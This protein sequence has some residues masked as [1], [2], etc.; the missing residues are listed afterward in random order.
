MLSSYSV[1]VQ[2]VP[3]RSAING[4]FRPGRTITIQGTVHPNATRSDFMG[5]CWILLWHQH[6]VTLTIHIYCGRELVTSHHNHE[7][8]CWVWKLPDTGGSS[9]QLACFTH[10]QVRAVFSFTTAGD[11]IPWTAKPHN[12][13]GWYDLLNLPFATAVCWVMIKSNVLHRVWGNTHKHY[14]LILQRS[15]AS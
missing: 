10:R 5:C 14:F 3:Y 4:G 13:M 6:Y 2:A 12:Q 9:L 15:V 8:A 7:T 1:S 11:L